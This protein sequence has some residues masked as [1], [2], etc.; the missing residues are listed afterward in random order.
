MKTNPFV[1]EIKVEGL[2]DVLM[3]PMPYERKPITRPTNDCLD[4]L[5]S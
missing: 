3:V 5:L 2:V 1:Y 4:R